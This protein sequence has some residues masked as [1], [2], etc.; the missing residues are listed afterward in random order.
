MANEPSLSELTHIPAIATG[1][2]AVAIDSSAM[3]AQLNQA[4]RAKAENDW[5]KYKTFL[6]NFN[7]VSRDIQEIAGLD[8]LQQDREVLD[9]QRG[10]IFDIISKN[11]RAMSG[12]GPEAQKLNSAVSK[13]R[14]DATRSKQDAAFDFAHR[15]L[16]GQNPEWNT[17]DNKKIIDGFIKQPLGQRQQYN[18]QMPYMV[19]MGA[20]LSGVFKDPTVT[21]VESGHR[22]E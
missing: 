2:P 3:V 6:D 14:S 10:E 18:L 7:N 15:H 20:L 9:K 19:D 12:I 5:R 1:K 13:Y 17:E 11:P 21:Q 22:I 16:L 4:A 8:V